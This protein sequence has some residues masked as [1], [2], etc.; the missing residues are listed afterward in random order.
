MPAVEG[1]PLHAGPVF[2]AT[3]HT[4]GDPSGAAYSYGRSHQPT[5]TVLEQ[6]LGELEVADG[7]AAAG[8]RVFASGLAAVAAVFGSVLR[9]GDAVAL[10]ANCYFGA[11]Q[12]LKELFEPMGVEVRLLTQ[13]QMASGAGFQGA[14]LIWLEVPT[15]PGLELTD[16]AQAA[17]RAHATGALL[18]VD[19]TTLTPLGQRPLELGA[20]FSVCSDSKMLSG[21][22]DV[23]LG[24]VA[25][26]DAALLAGLDR[27]RTLTGAIPGPMEAWLVLRS[28]PTLA[29]RMQRSAANARGVA[30][31]LRGHR[32]VEAVG[33][34]G[35]AGPFPQMLCA[36]P[37]LSFVLASRAA[38]ES[39][40]CRARLVTETTSFGAV[41]TT[42]ERRGRWGHD[43][44]APGFIRMSVGCED[45]GDLLAD[46]AQ[47]L[48]G[49]A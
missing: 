44:V 20:D 14:R 42:A 24:H 37:V 46:L 12:L 35:F 2:A 27:Y 33:Y 7:S 23:L 38:A 4:P 5:W 16:I 28:L 8:V 43:G 6:A 31:F 3:F 39:F 40:L 41:T 17:R 22:S 19:N 30:E 13:E 34:P 47:A 9:A 25:V 36:G 49:P 29:L 10:A 11:R 48:D 26:R 21:H 15:N 32:A 18:A 1:T 45:L